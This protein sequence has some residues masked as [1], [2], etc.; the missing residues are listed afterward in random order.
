ETPP[1]SANKSQVGHAMG[2]S[3]ALETI[4]AMEGMLGDVLLPTINY[5]P[6]PE[7]NIDCVAEGARKLSQEFVLKNA[8]GFGGCN[9]CLIL[10]RIA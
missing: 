2:A 3:S 10:R 6:D 4:F 7:I 5:L 1:V 8:F 9:S